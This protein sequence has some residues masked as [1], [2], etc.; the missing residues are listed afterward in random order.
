MNLLQ[1]ESTS[2][3]GAMRSAGTIGVRPLFAVTLRPVG[4][5]VTSALPVE[6]MVEPTE[7][8]TSGATIVSE[9][10]AGAV[11][12]ELRRTS[13]LTWD[14]LARLCGVSRRSLH[15]WASGST[16]TSANEEKLQRVLAEI[17]Q[18]DR[19]SAAANRAMLL[20][21]D[22]GGALPFDLL[23][24]GQYE[25]ARDAMGPGRGPARIVLPSLSQAEKDARAPMRPE[26]LVGALQDRIHR[27]N[28]VIRAARSAK[29]K[30]RG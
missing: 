1:R 15:F 26:D 19:G 28:K 5:S 14:Q 22:T 4:T 20:S 24:T 9:D 2:A 11:I 25:R 17:R 30:G 23:A 21:A 6:P 10:R 12:A 3:A 29:A 27:D 7:Q 8:T 13:G 16:M 18:A